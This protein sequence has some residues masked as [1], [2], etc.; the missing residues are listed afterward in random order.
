MLTEKEIRIRYKSIIPSKIVKKEIVRSRLQKNTALLL[1]NIYLTMNAFTGFI[2][3]S[4]EAVLY[5]T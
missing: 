2:L 3:L 4:S 5:K 1:C